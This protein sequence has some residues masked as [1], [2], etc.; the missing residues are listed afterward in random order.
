MKRFFYGAV[1]AVLFTVGLGSRAFATATDSL[2]LVAGSGANYSTLYIDPT[3][4]V[5][6]NDYGTSTACSGPY[7]ASGSGGAIVLGL[8]NFDGYHLQITS[9]GSN[10][11][12]CSG[13]PNGPGCLNTT[14]ITATN[15]TAGTQSITA[16]YADTGFTPAGATGLIVGFSTP[17]ETGTTA[18]QTAYATTGT[19]D[20]LGP[21]VETPTAGLS[22]CGT[23]GLKIS[24]PT[25]NASAGTSC[26]AP[27]TPFS[28][29][30]AT[31]MTT[32]AGGAFNLNGTI[33]AVPEPA[34][35]VLFGTVLALCASGLRRRR[36]LS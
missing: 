3:G 4:A 30:L 1:C 17:G 20:P 31:T 7:T 26:G 16:Y 29:E 8:A 32:T 11:P 35:V 19:I 9:G 10:S 23:P 27:G 24:G 25:S 18:L 14:N 36:K 21:G 5:T 22:V 13:F 28:L 34:A 6:C 12:N 15:V 33:S 2:E